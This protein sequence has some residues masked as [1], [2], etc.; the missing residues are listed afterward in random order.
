[1][2]LLRKNLTLRRQ[3]T[4]LL[5]GIWSRWRVHHWPLL[6]NLTLGLNRRERPT[7]HSPHWH[8]MCRLRLWVGLVSC[9]RMRQ[10]AGHYAFVQ[11]AADNER[12]AYVVDVAAQS[13]AEEADH[14]Q[15]TV[16]CVDVV[17]PAL[18]LELGLEA[19]IEQ[20]VEVVPGNE[21]E[22]VP[23][24]EAEIVPGTEAVEV[25]PGNE[26]EIVPGNEA[27]IVP[28]TEP[29]VGYKLEAGVAL[30]HATGVADIVACLVDKDSTVDKT[31]DKGHIQ[32]T[33]DSIAGTVVGTTVQELPQ[34]LEPESWDC[35]SLLIEILPRKL[36]SSS[37]LWILNLRS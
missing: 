32:H 13:R 34:Q 15:L 27:E 36:R 3:H 21:A 33:A 37:S 25:V 31:A 28:G 18:V 30:A 23:G 5:I 4:L 8:L 11:K 7:S 19:E 24:N 1:M 10:E 2:G 29:E 16:E 22:I 12:P 9:D 14:E 26:A 17:G 20:A 35:I 6:Q